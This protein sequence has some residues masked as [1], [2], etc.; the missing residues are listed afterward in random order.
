MCSPYDL[1][2]IDIVR[3]GSSQTR[4]SV[5]W[6]YSPPRLVQATVSARR[7]KDLASA[8]KRCKTWLDTKQS[9]RCIPLNTTVAKFW[10]M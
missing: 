7:K 2:R 3:P 1:S 6:K 10:F 9:Y 5:S 8:V 4:R